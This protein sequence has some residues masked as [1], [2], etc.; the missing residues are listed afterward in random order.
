VV[1]RVIDRILK[2]DE[3]IAAVSTG[4]MM[5]TRDEVS[6]GSGKTFQASILFLD[7]CGFTDR[8][9]STAEEQKK[10]LR[11]M[12]IFI[13]EMMNIVRDHEGIFEKNTGDGLMAYFGTNTPSEAETVRSAVE[14]AVLMHAFNDQALTKL[15]RQQELEPVRFRVGIDFGRV[16]IARIGIARTST[17]V[18]IGTTAN[19]ANRLLRATDSGICIGNEVYTRLPPGWAGTCVPSGHANGFVYAQ[20]RQPYPSWI[21][22][23]R[24]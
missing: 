9:S 13:P 14:A 1:D 18:A 4:E 15:L 20:S 24:P 12:N 16:T 19:I 11:M 10:V 23:Y 7:I 3:R 5:P 8:P 17:F 21:L 2:L 6:I 22:N